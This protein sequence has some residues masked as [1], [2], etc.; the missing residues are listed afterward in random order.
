MNSSK[1]ILITMSNVFQ[2]EPCQQSTQRENESQNDGID[3]VAREWSIASHKLVT[4]KVVDVFVGRALA[5]DRSVVGV[6]GRGTHFGALQVLLEFTARVGSDKVRIVAVETPNQTI[7]YKVT[8]S[9]PVRYLV[10]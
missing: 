7:V 2:S 5:N 6:G 10:E 9:D 8:R 3:R 1:V 4:E